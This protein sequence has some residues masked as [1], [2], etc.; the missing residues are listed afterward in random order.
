MLL[1]Y[2]A[3]IAYVAFILAGLG[4]AAGNVVYRAARRA[5]RIGG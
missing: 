5:L 4:Q 3:G 2:A 1:I